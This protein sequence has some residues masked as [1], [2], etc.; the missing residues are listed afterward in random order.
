[1]AINKYAVFGHPVSHSKSPAIHQQF[2]KQFGLDISYEAIDVPE[3][4]FEKTVNEFI[5]AGGQGLNITVPYKL[6][7]WQLADSRS[8]R[9][10][11]AGAVNTFKF[12]T[13]K[14]GDTKIIGDNT[15][16][17][18]LVT[19]IQK[20]LQFLINDK[21]VLVLGAGGAVR[22]V[23]A[24]LLDCSPKVLVIA[25]RTV[26]KAEALAEAFKEKGHIDVCGFEDLAGQQFD[27]VING[28][29][30]SL[31][32]EVPPIPETIFA[33]QALAYDMMYSNKPTLFMVWAAAHGAEKVAD[34]LGML[35]EQAAE[36][37]Y[38]WCKKRPDTGSV[39]KTLR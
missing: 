3:G 24:P 23:L 15:D 2:A 22:G 33:E 10:E 14:E 9:A 12:E 25:N 28:T 17:I 21:K 32:G 31:K 29:A 16:G 18:G 7:A 26:S 36:S 39:M 1:M 35:V 30:A 19:D 6:E 34:G 13:G 4:E 38:I 11:L 27:L 37:F 8:D 20:N 5:K